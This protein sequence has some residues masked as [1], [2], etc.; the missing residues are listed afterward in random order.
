MTHKIAQKGNL[1]DNN[2]RRH[3]LAVFL[4]LAVALPSGLGVSAEEHTDLIEEVQ[5]R[6][7]LRVGMSSFSPW[8]MRS[9][10]GEFIGF[11]VDV[12]KAVA[13]DLEVKLELVPT[14]WDGIIP[15]LLSKKFDVII[16]GMSINPKRNLKVNFTRPYAHS[17]LEV[18][19]N[20]DSAGNF[21]SMSKLNNPDVTIALR[22]GISGLATIQKIL[23]SATIKQFDDEA[24]AQQDVI[25]GNSDAWISAAPAPAFAAYKNP[26]AL[27]LLDIEPFDR[28]SEGFALRKGDPDALNFFNNWI[29][30]RT[31]S[32]WLKERHDYWFKTRDWE[33]QVGEQ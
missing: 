30:I 23:P 3:L 31:E 16:G 22:R 9:S 15:A 17:G 28:S 4:A 6:G 32:G 2:M 5:R 11:E 20:K 14:A 33:S 8:A 12:A 24:S 18:V 27:S 21:G 19:A 1:M 29:L 25:N 10:S 13:E 7:K 26:N